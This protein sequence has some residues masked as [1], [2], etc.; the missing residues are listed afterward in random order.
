MRQL[1]DIVNEKDSNRKGEA[2]VTHLGGLVKEMIALTP[3]LLKGF[4][5]AIKRINDREVSLLSKEN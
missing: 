4:D 2:I 5:E 1:P 3:Y